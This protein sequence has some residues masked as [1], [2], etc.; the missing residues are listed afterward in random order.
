MCC[1]HQTQQP[2]PY[3]NMPTQPPPPGTV[4]FPT[5]Y[6]TPGGFDYGTPNFQ[7]PPPGAPLGV[8]PTQQPQPVPLPPVVYPN[9]VPRPVPPPSVQPLV[10]KPSMIF[11]P[12]PSAAMNMQPPADAPVPG[13]PGLRV[14]NMAKITDQKLPILKPL[15]PQESSSDS[16]DD[17]YE[18]AGIP[19]DMP[20]SSF[21]EASLDVGKKAPIK[22][23]II[24]TVETSIEKLET[25]RSLMIAPPFI[26]N[27]DRNYESVR[28]PTISTSKNHPSIFLKGPSA[29]MDVTVAISSLNIRAVHLPRKPKFLPQ[30]RM[31]AKVLLKQAAVPTMDACTMTDPMP[32]PEPAECMECFIRNEK[33]FMNRW[34]QTLPPV[35]HSIY[36]QVGTGLE[37]IHNP[38]AFRNSNPNRFENRLGPQREVVLVENETIAFGYAPRSTLPKP[39]QPP[40]PPRYPLETRYKQR[41]PDRCSPPDAYADPRTRH[42]FV[43]HDR[44]AFDPMSPPGPNNPPPRGDIRSRL[45]PPD[46]RFFN[47]GGKRH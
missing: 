41:S 10:N 27:S 23:Y 35:R 21:L 18:V 43:D 3:Y 40:S 42:G 29:D 34:T 9:L 8:Q 1:P 17:D 26:V 33:D 47:Y 7:Q 11:N 24:D 25:D 44:P 5:P 2:A 20:L 37:S 12:P 13:R 4:N 38:V 28:K 22:S 14:V 46:D 6:Y 36:V 39:P 45:A 31:L 16:D 32:E 30:Q 19:T 15:P